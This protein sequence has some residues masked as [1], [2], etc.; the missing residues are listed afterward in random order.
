MANEKHNTNKGFCGMTG[1]DSPRATNSPY[2]AKHSSKIQSKYV[3]VVTLVQKFFEKY[4]Y[5]NDSNYAFLMALWTVATH[6]HQEVST[7]PYM[8]ITGM[9]MQSGKSTAA[10][11]SSFCAANPASINSITPAQLF[12]MIDGEAPTIY[13]DEA[14]KLNREN[15]PCREIINSGYR[16]GQTVRRTVGKETKE[17]KLYGPK[18]FILIGTTYSTLNDRSVVV[19]M[20]RATLEQR[21]HLAFYDQGVAKSE[22]ESIRESIANEINA[23]AKYDITEHFVNTTTELQFLSA[24]DAEIWRV[25]IATAKTFCPGRINEAKKVAADI[26]GEKSAPVV[27]ESKEEEEKAHNEEYKLRLLADMLRA[28]NGEK[29]IPSSEVLPRLFALDIA[30]WRKYKGRGITIDEVGMLMGLCGINS[31]AIQVGKGRKNRKV[32][33]GYSRV[34]LQNAADSLNLKAFNL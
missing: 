28:C 23:G 5:F 26:A 22:G 34:D 32:V 30:P 4:L 13:V 25:L 27:R 2:C 15:H 31:K 8:V 19:K 14:E 29:M 11:L 20:Q 17:F 10:E 1:C 9:T 6:V 18:C 7:F 16:K 12:R 24:R 21:Q 3:D 33:R